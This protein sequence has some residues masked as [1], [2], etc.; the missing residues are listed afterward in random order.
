MQQLV[1]NGAEQ[2][3]AALQGLAQIS[4]I[5]TRYARVEKI[6]IEQ[7]RKHQDTNLNKDFRTHVVNLYVNILVYQVA[8]VSHSKRHPISEFILARLSYY[9]SLTYFHPFFSAICESSS[10]ARRLERTVARNPKGGCRVQK[11]YSDL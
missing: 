11:F 9:A 10:K 5:L 1:L 6:Y 4:P 3:A 2:N 7:R 8:I